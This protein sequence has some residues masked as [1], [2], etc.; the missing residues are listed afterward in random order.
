MRCAGKG[1]E[2][3]SNRVAEAGV[4]FIRGKVAEITDKTIGDEP[5]GKLIVIVEDTLLGVILRIPVD[6]VVLAVAVEPQKDTEDVGRLFGL[7]RSADGFFLERHPKLDPVATMNDGI[8]IAGCA[9]GPKDIPQTV[10]QAQAAAA[11]VLATIAKGRIDLEP[12]VSEVI[13]ENCDGCAYCVDPCPYKAITLIE[14]RKDGETK[15]IVESDPV[16]CRGCGVC[17][18]TCP[19][20]GIVV[21]GFTPVQLRSMVEALIGCP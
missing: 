9:Q 15:K 6:M 5:K 20:A 13:L 8:F 19:K 14:Y 3:F 11:G 1:Y 7:S 10:A 2:E 21:K 17:M 12:R 4:N 18:A 16:K